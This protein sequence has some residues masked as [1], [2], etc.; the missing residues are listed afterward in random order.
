MPGQS[1]RYP[2][3]PNSKEEAGIEFA[4]ETMPIKSSKTEN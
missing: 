1:E 3:N 4:D 2:A